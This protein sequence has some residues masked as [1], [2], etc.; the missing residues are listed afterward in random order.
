MEEEWIRLD[1]ETESTDWNPDYQAEE[2]EMALCC[3]AAK[4]MMIMMMM[5]M[6][7]MQ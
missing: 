6:R 5:M 4:R 2:N 3:E 1:S 7:K